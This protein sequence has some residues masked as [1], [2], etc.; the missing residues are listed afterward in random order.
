MP[1]TGIIS[2]CQI[3]NL[4]RNVTSSRRFPLLFCGAMKG[5]A[6]YNSFLSCFD[7]PQFIVQTQIPCFVILRERKRPKNLCDKVYFEI[8]ILRYAQN[9]TIDCFS[10]GANFV[11]PFGFLQNLGGRTQF[12]PTLPV[13]FS[14]PN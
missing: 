6:P 5:I 1:T 14:A 13:L 12:S 7:N 8:E 4:E 10:V 9:D 3:K 2:L 11:R